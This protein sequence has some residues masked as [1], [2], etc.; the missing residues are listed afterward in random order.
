MVRDLP[1]GALAWCAFVRPR[2]FVIV[3]D[4]VWSEHG[5]R[6]IQIF[7]PG[8]EGHIRTYH[9]DYIVQLDDDVKLRQ[10][11]M[12]LNGGKVT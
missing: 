10:I 6:M 1:P 4:Y 12:I 8:Y 7:D 3:I 11:D 9:P 2:R 5:T